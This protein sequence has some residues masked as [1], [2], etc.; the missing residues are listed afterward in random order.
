MAKLLILILK[1]ILEIIYI[2]RPRIFG[3]GYNQYK[4]KKIIQ[5]INAKKLN[6]YCDNYLDERIVEI[7][8]VINK[9]KK[10][11]NNKILDVGCTLNFDYLLDYFQKNNKIFFI[12]IFKEK[13]SFFSN[14]ISYIQNDI[15]NSFF[16][17]NTFDVITCI[18][19]LEHIGFDNNIYNFEKKLSNKKKIINQKLFVSALKEMKRII[20]PG[21]KIFLSF[22]FGK[23]QLFLNYQQ[24]DFKVI[25]LI[26]KI[27]NP[28]KINL[29]FFKYE[30]NIWKFS[31]MNDCR[32]VQSIRKN[33]IGISAKAVALL[34]ITK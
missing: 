4:K 5:N 7:P 30:N 17:E 11:K 29:K 3:L 22:P 12:N 1:K 6:L 16:Q 19:V 20:K 13:N 21:G 2:L 18:S 23:K 33:K 28:R 34:E 25:N 15:C 14:N 27:F 26:N 10:R 32:N 31:N 24:F 8:W 9:I